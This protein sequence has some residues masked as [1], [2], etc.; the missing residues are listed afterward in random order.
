MS[1]TINAFIPLNAHSAGVPHKNLRDFDGR[2]LFHVIVEA[3]RR[4]HQIGTIYIDT[5]RDEI[6]ASASG[7]DDVLVIGRR[8]D[9]VG[10][11]VSMNRL[12]EAFFGTHDDPD[13]LLTHATNPL[14]RSTTVDAAV[15]EYFD[16]SS[17]GSTFVAT[18]PRRS[19]SRSSAC[20]AMSSSG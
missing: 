18:V 5:D 15:A 8:P 10:D 1:G 4:A 17:I 14:L 12:I 11:G 20:V 16:D 6:A 2:P 19:H 7:L 3:L 13:L 9:L